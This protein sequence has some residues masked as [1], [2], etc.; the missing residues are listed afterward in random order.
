[1]TWS[2]PYRPFSS[3]A[4]LKEIGRIIFEI[5]HEVIEALRMEGPVLSVDPAFD[6]ELLSLRSVLGLEKL[7]HPSCRELGCLEIELFG[8]DQ[9]LHRY[10]AMIW[11]YQFS[12]WVKLINEGFYL[13]DLGLGDKVSL[14]EYYHI[15]KLN[16]I[17]QELAERDLCLLFLISFRHCFHNLFYTLKVFV[18]VEAV[19]YSDHSVKAGNFLKTKAWLI[20]E[21]ESLGDWKRLWNSSGFNQEVVEFAFLS[22]CSDLFD[23]ILSKSAAYAAVLHFDELLLRP[24]KCCATL[25][26]QPSVDVDL[27]HVIDDDGDAVALTILK[28]LIH[29]RGLA[30]SQEPWEHCHR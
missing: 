17:D 29:Y 14:I 4:G 28:Y 13:V 19:N 21:I 15:R 27:A 26:H 12:I 10:I 8:I 11:R 1:M 9:F 3:D 23:K 20:C 5:N 6:A 18:K 16:L 24:L 30:G 25:L 2:K 22:Q 7:F